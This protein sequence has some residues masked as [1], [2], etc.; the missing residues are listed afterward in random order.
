MPPLLQ[1]TF[2]GD[3]DRDDVDTLAR[4]LAAAIRANLEGRGTE[5]A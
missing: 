1:D 4:C 2:R 3:A 5:A